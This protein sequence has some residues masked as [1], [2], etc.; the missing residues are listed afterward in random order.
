M[1]VDLYNTQEF[2]LNGIVTLSSSLTLTIEIKTKTE[3]KSLEW[4][5]SPTMTV[6]GKTFL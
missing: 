2:N 1:G 4:N 6:M 3:L 5:E